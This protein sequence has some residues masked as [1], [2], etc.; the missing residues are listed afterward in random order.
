MNTRSAFH[1]DSILFPFSFFTSDAGCALVFFYVSPLDKMQQLNMKPRI[2]GNLKFSAASALYSKT[3]SMT[4]R[5]KT[6]GTGRRGQE[7]GGGE[8]VR[9]QRVKSL[10]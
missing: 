3:E 1:S 8:G 5:G 9:V 4:I 6:M 2:E 10:N 7:G